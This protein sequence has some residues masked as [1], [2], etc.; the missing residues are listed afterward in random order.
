MSLEVTVTPESTATAVP[1]SVK[2][3]VV[4]DGFTTGAAI[5][6]STVSAPVLLGTSPVSFASKATI[7]SDR[8]VLV[9]LV[10]ENVT[11]CK[12]AVYWLGVALPVRLSTP[13]ELL[14]IVMPSIGV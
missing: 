3:L 9:V 13:P 14:A 10:V 1:P 8:A 6:T 2:V 4:P 11:D 7:D 5:S 12:A